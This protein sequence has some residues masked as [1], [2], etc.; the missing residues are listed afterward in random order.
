[1]NKKTS[2]VKIGKRLEQ[3]PDERRYTND[4]KHL[5]RQ[6]TLVVRAKQM[7][8]TH[9]IALH[10]HQ[11]GETKDILPSDGQDVEQLE[12][13]MHHR[14]ECKVVEHTGKLSGSF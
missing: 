12:L 6:S 7:T 1:M 4:H 10:T 13:F 8:T 14:W 5:K 11:T 3:T 2:V 9:D